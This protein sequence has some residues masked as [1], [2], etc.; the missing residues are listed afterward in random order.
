MFLYWVLDQGIVCSLIYLR[1]KKTL[2]NF[3]GFETLNTE[4]F[5]SRGKPL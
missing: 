4:L 5:F 1:A 3:T 2:R